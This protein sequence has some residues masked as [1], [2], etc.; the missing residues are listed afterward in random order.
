MVNV[1]QV[2]TLERAFLSRRVKPLPAPLMRAVEAGLRLVL[3]L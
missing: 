2:L 3:A 1:S